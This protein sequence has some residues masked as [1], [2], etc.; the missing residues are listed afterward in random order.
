M[1]KYDVAAHCFSDY[2]NGEVKPAKHYH[3]AAGKYYSA[4]DAPQENDVVQK[5]RVLYRL[6]II[7]FM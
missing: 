3:V 1:F 5:R 6:T 4:Y 2:T 7:T